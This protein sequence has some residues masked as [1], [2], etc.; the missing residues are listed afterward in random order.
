MQHYFGRTGSVKDEDQNLITDSN[1][2]KA[3]RGGSGAGTVKSL[4]SSLA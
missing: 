4:H 1:K 3:D 2:T